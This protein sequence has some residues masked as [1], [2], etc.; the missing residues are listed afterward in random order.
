M[1]G[2]TPMPATGAAPV[3]DPVR[4]G[5]ADPEVARRLMLL[6]R[7][8]LGRFPAGV[9]GAQRESEAQEMFQEVAKQAVASAGLFDPQ[10]GSLLHWLG[11]IVWN[12]AKKR[13]PPRYA[14]TE[15]ATL[16]ETVPDRRCPIPEDVASRLDS[17]AILER[18]PPDD[19]QLLRLHA[20]GRT[21]QE[22]AE[23]LRL[24]PGNVRVRISRT[25]RR[26]RAMLR[27][28]DPEADHD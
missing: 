3:E 13:R 20:E 10:R 2:H 16:A 4:Q 11:G 1:S 5:L 15:P 22:I 23:E 17:R 26:L 14:A 6:I 18:L 7:A 24:T 28:P 19:A 21:A 9:T 27:T 12:V 25:L 8:A